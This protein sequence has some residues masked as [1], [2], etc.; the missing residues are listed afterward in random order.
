MNNP[1]ILFD[2]YCNF[3]SFW[4]DFIIKRDKKKIFKFAALQSE[5]AKKLFGQISTNNIS[6][7]SVVLFIDN[8]IFFKSTAA[9]KIVQLIGLPW[10]I[11]YLFSFVPKGLRDLIYDYVASNR[12]KIFGKRDFCRIPSDEDRGRFLK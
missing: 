8:Q 5:S 3:C 2:G 1:I 11:F 6:N 10:K 12:F 7:E 4:V 9:I